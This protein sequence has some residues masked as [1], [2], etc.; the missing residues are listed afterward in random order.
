MKILEIRSL[1]IPD[2]KVVRY[3]RF[4]DDR[5]YFTET[6]RKSDFLG[7][8]DAACFH[9]VEFKQMQREPI[10]GGRDPRTALPMEPESG[11]DGAD[12]RRP[13]HRP[14]PG[15][16]QGIAHVWQDHRLRPAGLARG[17]RLA[18]GSGCRPALPIARACWSIRRSS[19]S[20]PRSGPRETRRASRRW[21][22]ISTGRCAIRRS[23]ARY[24]RT[25]A[26]ALLS[27]KDRDG[28]SLAGLARRSAV[29]TFCLWAILKQADR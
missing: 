8:A 19:I 1:A 29:A 17:R 12:H 21:P 23:K 9:G 25:L 6:F 4:R 18:T 3:A 22:P 16:P 7:H 24:D 28:F 20:V 14:G 27:P 11:Q 13:H 2:V 10:A 26:S 15:Y 5:G